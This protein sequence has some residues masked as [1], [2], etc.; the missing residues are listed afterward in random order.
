MERPYLPNAVMFL[1]VFILANAGFLADRIVQLFMLFGRP[2]RT[3]GDLPKRSGI[4]TLQIGTIAK[5][6]VTHD[7]ILRRAG[8]KDVAN[9]RSCLVIFGIGFVL[10]R[11][12]VVTLQSGIRRWKW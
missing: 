10:P 6:W 2:C 5:E 11:P 7:L 3:F 1:S 8:H 4:P 9:Y 12:V